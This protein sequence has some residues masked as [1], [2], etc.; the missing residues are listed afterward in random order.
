LT[1]IELKLHRFSTKAEFDKR[2]SG[3]SFMQKKNSMEKKYIWGILS[4]L[5]S[6]SEGKE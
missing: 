6:L 5:L 1:K 2:R 4:Y 3:I